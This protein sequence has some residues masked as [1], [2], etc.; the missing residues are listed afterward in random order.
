M[1]RRPNVERN[2][3]ASNDT[4]VVE[5][6]EKAT[7]SDTHRAV[8]SGESK[9]L[10]SVHQLSISSLN[11]PECKPDAEGEGIQRHS[12]EMWRDLLVDSMK[13]LGI[14][15]ES[16]M[17]TIFR[18][19]AGQQLLETFKN[20][21]SDSNAPAAETFPFSNAMHRLKLYFGSGSDVMLQRR[22]LATMDQ[23]PGESDLSYI[24]RVGATARL[25]DFE[26]GKQF[27]QIV[28]T[29]AEHALRKDVRAIA[30]KMLSRNASFTD[31]V[32]KIRELEAIR[33]NEEFFLKKTMK[34]DLALVA[35]VRADFPSN[36]GR[37][38]T[39]VQK[40]YPARNYQ[41]PRFGGGRA[42]NFQYN[43]GY[44]G[45]RDIERNFAAPQANR[46]WRCNS[47]YHM[48][49][50]CD[51]VDKVCRNCGIPGHLARTCTQRFPGSSLSRKRFAESA[52]ETAPSPKL[53]AIEAPDL[54]SINKEEVSAHTGH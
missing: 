28:S 39:R 41:R 49:S 8:S 51:A 29:I 26:E 9:L 15:D 31:L 11:V 13:L 12:F 19:K 2:E 18:V 16:T 46:C 50:E 20:T 5:V 34:S 23:K 30:L 3:I 21:K 1:L 7:P 6:N 40:N 44:K 33:L 27:E 42:S 22:K 54:E 37:Q 17:F 53:A 48:P 25:C 52:P 43:R 10:S 47:V 36:T 32:D 35:P 4:G 38:G 24:G 45:R 14:Q